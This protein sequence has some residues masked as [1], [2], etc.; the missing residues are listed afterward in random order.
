MLEDMNEVSEAMG[1]SYGYATLSRP[2]L[3]FMTVRTVI[4]LLDL[5]VAV[6][7]TPDVIDE[8][9]LEAELA[10]LDD[11]DM[12]ELLGDSTPEYL[13]SAPSLPVQPSGGVLPTAPT[14]VPTSP[15]RQ[16]DEYGL[17]IQHTI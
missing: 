1:R 9:D 11:M 12:D 8:A 14:T 15:S 6:T 17:P 10:V 3:K 13:Q 16:T 5:L 7:S 2:V 4:L